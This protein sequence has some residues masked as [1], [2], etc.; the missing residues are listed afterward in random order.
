MPLA[1]VI[2][3]WYSKVLAVWAYTGVA[4]GTAEPAIQQAIWEVKTISNFSSPII[5]VL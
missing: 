2:L 3:F 4:T 5:D 1:S